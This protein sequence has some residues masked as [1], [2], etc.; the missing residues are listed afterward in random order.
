[1]RECAEEIPLSP[2]FSS[3]IVLLLPLRVKRKM[4]VLLLLLLLRL[5]TAMA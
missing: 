2:S 5:V 1:M 3:P 4:A